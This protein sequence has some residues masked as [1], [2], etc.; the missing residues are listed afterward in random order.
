MDELII[1][2]MLKAYRYGPPRVVD[3]MRIVYAVVEQRLRAKHAEEM[4]GPLTSAEIS[5][6]ALH[7]VDLVQPVRRVGCFIIDNAEGLL[8]D[9]K[10]RF[11]APEPKE[12]VT[13]E[14]L[15][16]S[17]VDIVVFLDGKRELGF[18][19]MRDAER[20]AAGLRAELEGK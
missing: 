7:S 9:R 13:I 4:L 6:Y 1:E 12:R 8:S 20:Y 11:L 10:R 3:R 18:V 2:E 15:P 5:Q 16:G 19:N 17:C 14:Q